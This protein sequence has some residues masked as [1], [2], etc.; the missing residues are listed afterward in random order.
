[1]KIDSPTLKRDSWIKLK[2][3][4]HSIVVNEPGSVIS[5]PAHGCTS[6]AHTYKRWRLA[7]EVV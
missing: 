3:L 6:R 7:L 5:S 1:M 2:F 4:Y